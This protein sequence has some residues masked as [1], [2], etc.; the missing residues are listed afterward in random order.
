V[1]VVERLLE[2]LDSELAPVLVDEPHLRDADV[3]VD[4]AVRD[5]R[6]CRLDPTSWPQ[7]RF[8]K[9]SASSSFET[10]KPL[11]SSGLEPSNLLG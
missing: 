10:T 8:T 1:R 9:L 2:R 6:P 11:R 4:P 3:L 7:R 5:D